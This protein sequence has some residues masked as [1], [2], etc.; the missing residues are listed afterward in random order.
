M[1]KMSQELERRID[2]NKYEL[3]EACRAWAELWNWKPLDSG[4]NMQEILE[5]SWVQTKRVLAKIENAEDGIG[6]ESS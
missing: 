2:E 3:W 6:T 1:S 5:R 4:D